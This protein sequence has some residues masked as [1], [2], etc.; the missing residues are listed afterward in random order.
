M[1]VKR[2]IEDEG[3]FY[4]DTAI[5][6]ITTYYEQ[7]KGKQDWNAAAADYTP[8][9][10]ITNFIKYLVNTRARF[11][12]GK[13]PF[14]NYKDDDQAKLIADILKDNKFHS[15]LLK[16]RKDCSIG[17]KIAIK[18]WADK[19][20]GVKVIFVP[21]PNFFVKYNPDDASIIDKVI[22]V[23]EVPGEDP[24]KPNIKKQKWELVN[25]VCLLTEDNYMND[26][27]LIDTPWKDFDTSLDFVP[28]IVVMNGGLTGEVEGVSDVKDIWDN[29]NA[30]NKLNSDDIDALKFQMFGQNVATDASEDSI[31]GMIISPGALIDLQTDVSQANAGR[32]AKL[33]RVESGFGYKDKF[34]DTIDRIKNDMFDAMSVPNVG[35]EQLKGVISSGKAMK[36]LYWGLISACEEDWAEWGPAL[37]ELAEYIF[38]MVSI[39]N[40]YEAKAIADAEDKEMTIEH[41][42]PIQEDEDEEKKTDLEEIRAYVRSRASYIQK[43]QD[44]DDVDAELQAIE[45]EKQTFEVDNFTQELMSDVQGSDVGST[46]GNS[47]IDAI[48]AKATT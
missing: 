33:A 25:G 13:E 23:Y 46:E 6:D 20:I 14:F 3:V 27:T 15:K 5:K 31:S 9:K 41:Y 37:E 1:D 42:Y 48:P 2:F 10:K 4:D 19:D 16:A 11:M 28:V 40:L 44:V 45:L 24:A 21:A 22:F 12:F 29:Q 36:S 7:Y 38:R 26:G 39:F 43:W 8:T 32:Q 35:V 18:L 17:G 30:Y 34:E 47:K